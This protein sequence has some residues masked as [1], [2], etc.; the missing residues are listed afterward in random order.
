MPGLGLDN[1]SGL[2][3][4]GGPSGSLQSFGAY[5]MAGL[6]FGLPLSRLYARYFGGDLMIVNMPGYGVDA[7]LKLNVLGIEGKSEWKED[8]VDG[9]TS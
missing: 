1:V 6:G 9:H 7:F 8:S 3:A 4:L 2:G 5:R